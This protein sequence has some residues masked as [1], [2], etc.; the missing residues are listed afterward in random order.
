MFQ[1]L[2]NEDDL[3]TEDLICLE[4]FI[5]GFTTVSLNPNI[6]GEDVAK[7]V[8]EVNVHHHTKTCRKY[9]SSCRFNYPRFPT[10]NTIVAKP[11]KGKK[12]D[13][14]KIM[15]SYD[16]ILQKVFEVR[17]DRKMH[18]KTL[19]LTLPERADA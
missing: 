15:A 5:D 6:V 8:M 12:E 13:R 11:F 9:D 18:E 10:P 14:Q 4:N 7:L 17:F 19:K 2:R 3:A 16:E 1:K